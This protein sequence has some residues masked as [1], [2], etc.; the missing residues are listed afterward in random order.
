M[1]E[2]SHATLVDVTFKRTEVV[3][4]TNPSSQWV[5]LAGSSITAVDSAQVW[6]EVRRSETP[7]L[8][9]D[10]ALTVAGVG[11]LNASVSVGIFNT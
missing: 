5:G 4:P 11:C 6:L 8:S 1:L 9:R 3:T 7:P 10:T 2:Q